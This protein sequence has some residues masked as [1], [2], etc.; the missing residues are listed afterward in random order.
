MAEVVAAADTI[1]RAKNRSTPNFP[2]VSVCMLPRCLYMPLCLSF[3]LEDVPG[4]SKGGEQSENHA[5]GLVWRP[6]PYGLETDPLEP[7]TRIDTGFRV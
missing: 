5:V 7:G 3:S 4:R 1:S 6:T 2:A